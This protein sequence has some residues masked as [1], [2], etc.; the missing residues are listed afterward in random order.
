MLLKQLSRQNEPQQKIFFQDMASWRLFG[1]C[2]EAYS[3]SISLLRLLHT[4]ESTQPLIA[5]PV[6]LASS[7]YRTTSAQPQV[8]PQ[9]VEEVQTEDEPRVQPPP[10]PPLVDTH[11]VVKDLQKAGW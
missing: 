3:T 10:L 4:S 9:V 6:S 2:S 7:R 1:R 5:A 8:R 11:K